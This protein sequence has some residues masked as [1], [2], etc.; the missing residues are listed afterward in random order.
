MLSI[1][2]LATTR[3]H[4]LT[5]SVPFITLNSSLFI[6][7]SSFITLHSQ[8]TKSFQAAISAAID[9][10]E[11]RRNKASSYPILCS[12][13]VERKGIKPVNRLKSQGHPS[14]PESYTIKPVI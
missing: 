10:K 14:L 11:I 9:H 1:P 6:L 5:N 8:W 2:H 7:H 13:Q 12:G 4:L 3:V